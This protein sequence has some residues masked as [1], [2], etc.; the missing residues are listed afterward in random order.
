MNKLLF[1]NPTLI[2]NP[3]PQARN[4]NTAQLREP[5]QTLQILLISRLIKNLTALKLNTQ[6]PLRRHIKRNGNQVKDRMTT[7]TPNHKIA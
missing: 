7:R 6:N 3:N 1:E 5:P 2:I 4:N